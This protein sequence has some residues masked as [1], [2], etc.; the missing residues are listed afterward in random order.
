MHVSLPTRNLGDAE[1]LRSIANRID[2]TS[3]ENVDLTALV[4]E[5]ERKVTDLEH[6]IRLIAQFISDHGMAEVLTT[7]K[8]LELQRLCQ[9]INQR[10]GH[11]QAAQV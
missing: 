6:Q 7:R 5:L 9:S 2:K 3:Q 11:G 8:T 10:H 4:A 1:C